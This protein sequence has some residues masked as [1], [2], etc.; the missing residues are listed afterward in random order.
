VSSAIAGDE[1][2]LPKQIID[3]HAHVWDD[4]SEEEVLAFQ[5]V[6]EKYNIERILVSGPVPLVSQLKSAMPDRIIG[7]AVFTEQEELPSLEALANLYDDGVITVLGEI[8]AQYAGVS[9]ADSRFKPYWKFAADRRMIV[10]VHTGFGQP[11]SPYIP[12]LKGFRASFGQPLEFEDALANHYFMTPYLT[13]GGWPYLDQTKALLQLYPQLYLDISVLGL[14]PGI[15]MSEFQ[16]YLERLVIA[17][18][19]KRIMF[20]SGLSPDDYAKDIE[21]VIH[22]IQSMP[23]LTQEQKDDIFYGNAAR[24]IGLEAGYETQWREP[25][26]VK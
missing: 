24:F 20:G 26:T 12:G 19:G 23:F 15:P 22:Q 13:H 7:G 5:D 8:D 4:R 21:T 6:L 14:N 9:L 18:H 3:M 11:Y 1:Y 25:Q 2:D 16:D 17:G 10:S